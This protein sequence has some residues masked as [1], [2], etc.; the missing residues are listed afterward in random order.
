[1]SAEIQGYYIYGVVS[2]DAGLGDPSPAGGLEVELVEADDL[3]A[4]VSPAGGEDEASVRESVMAHAR[5]L[6]SAI[7]DTTVVPM[8][9]GM[10][11]PDEETVVRDLLEA[12][13]DELAHW[14]ERLE[15]HA[16]MTLK[17]YYRE[18]GVLREIVAGNDEIARLRDA[19]QGGDEQ[20]TYND[21][22]RLGELVNAEI[23]QRRERD[24]A[25]ILGRLEP[26]TV[27]SIS[28]PPEKEFMVLNAPLLIEQR[29]V[30]EL[31]QRLEEI[32]EERAELLTFRLV[33]PM[34]AYHF[35][36]WEEPAWA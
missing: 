25:E 22:V 18:D 28:E 17:V 23:E 15:G 11:F 10:V 31:E 3:A 24:S 21:R 32:A 12:R 14:L 20:T 4:I 8:R 13:H 16:Q 2:A 1:M 35:V 7:R 34:P 9:F 5:V 19:T 27:A 26:L 29:R 36:S 33:G 30:P 6:E